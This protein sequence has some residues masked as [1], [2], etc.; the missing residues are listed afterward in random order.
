M[1]TRN[2]ALACVALAAL[3]GC[4]GVT[5]ETVQGE[6]RDD[7]L[8]LVDETAGQSVWIELT[9]VGSEACELLVV[10]SEDPGALPVEGG[11]VE[12]SLGGEG[13]HRTLEEMYVEIDGQARGGQEPG[14]SVPVAP[15]ESARLQIAFTGV[16]ER[17]DRV[18][19][20]NGEG[21]YGRGRYAVLEFER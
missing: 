4:G 16:P 17:E 20:C 9:N 21:D 15:G 12:A 8:S 3:T 19:L 1:R 14:E 2:T 13:G 7:S 10:M 11:R 6:I 18:I 5:E